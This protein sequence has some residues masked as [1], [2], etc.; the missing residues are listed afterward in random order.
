[1]ISRTVRHI[2]KIVMATSYG[3]S[4]LNIYIYKLK[5]ESNLCNVILLMWHT[6]MNSGHDCSLKCYLITCDMVSIIG[7]SS[8]LTVTCLMCTESVS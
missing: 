1:M 6:W 2:L 7:I 3:K 8:Y 4:R 5:K